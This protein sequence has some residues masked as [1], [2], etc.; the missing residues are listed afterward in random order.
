[1]AVRHVFAETD[2][3]QD[4]QI[5]HFALDGA[6]RFCTIPS[7]A[8]APVAISSLVSGSPKRMTAGMPSFFTSAALLDRFVDGEIEDA[9][10][11]ANF[12]AHSLTRAD[13]ERIDE[14]LG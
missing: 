11:G 4:Q 5:G 2:I 10:H 7:S 13:E 1:V 12:L 6:R 3:A 8:Q 14:T 9:G